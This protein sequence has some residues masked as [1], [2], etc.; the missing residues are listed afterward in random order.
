MVLWFEHDLYDQLQ[1]LQIVALVAAT[2]FEPEQVELI[3]V[4]SFPGRPSFHGLGELDVAELRSLWPQRVPLPRGV[5]EIGRRAWDA[6]R[7]PEPTGI[8]GL[9]AE[10][11]SAMPFLEPALRR[12]LQ[13]FPDARTGLSRGER[14][15]L[16]VLAARP[17]RPGQAFEASIEL[18][19][20]PFEGDTWVWRRLAG[21][22][23]GAR[24]LVATATGGAMPRPPPLGD[25]DEFAAT[26][27]GLTDAGRA[28][29]AGREDLVELLGIDRWLGGTHLTPAGLWR[30]IQPP[31][32]SSARR[33]AATSSSIRA[34]RVSSTP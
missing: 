2:G 22:A 9:V 11:T 19:E 13:E 14:Q 16:E 26:A 7:A 6:F 5:V 20:A 1:L 32:A 18:E 21:L 29:L 31:R 15:L 4:G 34:T 28:V 12:L 17:L 3:S 10:D 30:W 33:R 25:P 24:P 8:H 23:T 27:I